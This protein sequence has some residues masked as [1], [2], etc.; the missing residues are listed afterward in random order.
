MK[1]VRIRW[2]FGIVFLG[3]VSSAV[4]SQTR[5]IDP[6]GIDGALLLCGGGSVSQEA[7]DRFIALAGGDKARIVIV[8]TKETPKEFIEQLTAAADKAK[9]A[10]PDVHLITDKL[11]AKITG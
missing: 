9:A 8:K 6:A 3:C 1:T 4:H 10:A 11:N 7:Q 2:L 5:R